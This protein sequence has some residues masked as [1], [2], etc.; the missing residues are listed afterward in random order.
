MRRYLILALIIGLCSASN[1]VVNGDF[2][3]AL[4][5]GWTPSSSGSNVT[6]ARDTT[7]HSDPDYEAYVRKGSGSGYAKLYQAIDIPILNLDISFSAKFYA[8]DNHTNAWAA[9]AVVI[10]YIDSSDIVLGETRIYRW[11]AGCPWS[12]SPTLHLIRV[13]D[14]NWNDYSFNIEDELVFL[15]GVD[16]GEIR[17]IGIALFANTYWC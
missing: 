11:S 1:Y 7:Y 14:D 10:S 5:V 2:E 3:Q 8:N 13:Y 4:T 9:A 6:I 17:K 16:P 12:E 15:P